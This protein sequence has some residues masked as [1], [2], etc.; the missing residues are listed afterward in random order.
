[1]SLR[2]VWCRSYRVILRHGCESLGSLEPLW[3][4]FG[5]FC[6]FP[7]AGCLIRRYQHNCITSSH[8]QQPSS[9][10]YCIKNLLSQQKVPLQISCDSSVIIEMSNIRY[11]MYLSICIQASQAWRESGW[12]PIG[13]HSDLIITTHI[14]TA[15]SKQGYQDGALQG[16]WI[17]G[18]IQERLHMQVIHYHPHISTILCISFDPSPHT[19]VLS[20]T[21]S[22]W[23]VK[24]LRRKNVQPPSSSNDNSSTIPRKSSMVLLP[25]S[26]MVLVEMKEGLLN[27]S[28]HLS[29]KIM[30]GIVWP[31]ARDVWRKLLRGEMRRSRISECQ[32]IFCQS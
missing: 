18:Q 24:L 29:M 31:S 5:V 13:L 25:S 4:R 30:R 32:Q 20:F 22:I 17:L 19:T 27:V 12:D 9:L 11:H 23:H 3:H 1:M 6:S 21:A 16:L 14:G 28:G 10:T 15:Y 26:H 2:M 8:R 7:N